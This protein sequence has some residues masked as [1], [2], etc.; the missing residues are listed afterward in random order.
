MIQSQ[1]STDVSIYCTKMFQLWLNK[2][3]KA[4]WNQLIV[5]LRYID[6]DH[7]AT[8]IEQMLLQ[9]KPTGVDIIVHTHMH[10]HTRT[11]TTHTHN[12]QHTH[13]RTHVFQK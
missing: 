7:L 12:T 11:H 6:L 4:S 9:P 10:T 1:H 2:Q 13:T 5:S 8:K 3:P